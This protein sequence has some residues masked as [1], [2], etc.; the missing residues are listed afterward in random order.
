MVNKDWHSLDK[1]A[2]K[3]LEGCIIFIIISITIFYMKVDV[4][5]LT[6]EKTS[7]KFVIQPNKPQYVRGIHLTSWAA[8]SKKYRKKIESLLNEKKINTLVIAVKEYSGEVYIPGVK[9]AEEFKTYVNAIPD[10]EAYLKDLKTIGIYPVARIVVFKDNA[11]AKKRL[12]WAV[13]NPDGSIWK[14]YKGQAWLDPYNKETWEYIFEIAERAV[15][16]GFEEIQ[17][18]YIRFPSDGVIKNCRYSQSHSSITAIKTIVDFLAE[19]KKRLK[20]KYGVN[21]SV[22][23]FGLTTSVE[24]DMGIGQMLLEIAKYVDFLCPMVYPSHYAKGEYGIPDPNKEPYKTVYKS[25]K[26]AS[27]RLG[28]DYKK[29]RPYLQDFSLGKKY[30]LK[31][32]LAQIKASYEN[33]IFEWTLWNPE[34]DYTTDVFMQEEVTYGVIKNRNEN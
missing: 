34:A 8:G 31:E 13:K 23:I 10:L 16:L 15:N 14:D 25:L 19:A 29:L 32:V 18:D 21:I 24:H 7:S 4:E 11:T 6:K 1:I 17:F 27:L 33:N 2:L 26:D 28:P 3:K 12:K 22:D 20:D 30:G 5:S 9:A